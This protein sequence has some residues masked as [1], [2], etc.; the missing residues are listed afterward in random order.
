MS[1]RK[2]AAAVAARMDSVVGLNS[3]FATA[4]ACRERGSLAHELERELSN[5]PKWW[6][7]LRGEAMAGKAGPNWASSVDDPLLRRS[8][9]FAGGTRNA[10]DLAVC[11][12]QS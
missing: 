4:Q 9:R 10:E 12:S 3:A 1:T 5:K 2:G 6:E 7:V 8:G 11:E